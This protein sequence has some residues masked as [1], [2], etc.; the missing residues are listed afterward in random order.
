MKVTFQD[1]QEPTNVASGRVMNTPAEVAQLFESLRSRP[2]FMF[3]LVGEHGHS[4]TVGYS[5]SVGAAQ[6]AGSDGRPPYLMAVNEESLDD[7]AVVEFLAGGTPTPIAGR[8]CLPIQR[9]LEIAQRFVA[10]GERSNAVTWD[11]I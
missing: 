10:T 11:E 7:E 4:L 5:N 2:P 8:F 3:E 9:V 6:Y 1:Q